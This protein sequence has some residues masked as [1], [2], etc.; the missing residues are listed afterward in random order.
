MLQLM[1]L[2]HV[3]VFITHSTEK[4]SPNL[5]RALRLLCPRE[6]DQLPAFLASSGL[7]EAISISGKSH[8]LMPEKHIVI[9]MAEA[10]SPWS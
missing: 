2:I 5:Q 9:G 6:I 4:F 3:I 8:I 1:S 7:Q 10:V